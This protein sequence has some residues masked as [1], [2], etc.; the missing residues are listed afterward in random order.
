MLATDRDAL[1]CDLAE[2]YHIYDYKMLPPATVAVLSV[3]LRNDSRIKLKMNDLRHPLQTM[4]T[5]LLVDRMSLLVWMHSQDG[6]DGVN[7]PKSLFDA[8]MGEECEGNVI[9][10][11]TPEEFEAEKEKI[12]RGGCE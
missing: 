1:I 11:E 7:R 5:A 9:G 6:A 3:G 2:T 10:F 12:L 8:L 4:L